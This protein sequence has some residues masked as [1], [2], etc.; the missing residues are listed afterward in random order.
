MAVRWTKEKVAILLTTVF[1]LWVAFDVLFPLSYWPAKSLLWG[2]Q[3]ENTLATI[4]IG[5]VLAIP[6]YFAISE[7]LPRGLRPAPA[8]TVLAGV[9]LGFLGGFVLTEFLS[10]AFDPLAALAVACVGAAVGGS[11]A[12]LAIRRL[13]MRISA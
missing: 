5:V 4:I 10:L 1:L 12:I 13:N 7:S 6:A 2:R 11:A 9:L 8:A 3:G